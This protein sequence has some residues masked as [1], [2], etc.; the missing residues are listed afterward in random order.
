MFAKSLKNELLFLKRQKIIRIK[1][2]YL[3][4]GLPKIIKFIHS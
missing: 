3:V 4:L 1:I 2:S